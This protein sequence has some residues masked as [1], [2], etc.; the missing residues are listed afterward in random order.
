M[1]SLTQIV[2]GASVGEAVCGKKAGNKAL[3]WGAI[4]GTIPD[5][6]V[7]AS[8]FLDLV[9]ELYYHRS[10][11]HS[12]LFA[13]LASPIFGWMV[14][15]IDKKGEA[16]F[17]DWTW[18]FF[19]GFTTHVLLDCFTTWGTKV[20]YPFSDYAVSFHNIFVIDPLY[21]IPFLI[22][23]VV[24]MFYHRKDQR[25]SYWNYT[26]IVISSAYMLLTLINKQIV[27]SVMVENL[28]DQKKSYLR[29]STKPTPFN[30]IL[31]SGTAE[32]DSGYFIGY[33]SFFDK[34][35]KV[36]FAYFPK[37]HHLLNPYWED[38][39]LQTLLNITEGYYTVEDRGDSLLIND[40]RFGQLDGWGKGEEG[41]AFVYIVQPGKG[42]LS[43]SQVPNDTKKA[44][45]LLGDL[46]KRIG[47]EE[48]F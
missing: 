1:D 18:L 27:N 36:D 24:L 46:W 41:F 34:D 8:P 22:C 45:A 7:L 11:T 3:L 4:A 28:N 21:T 39:K 40:L 12:I 17:Y 47:G 14:K 33:Y 13:F 15:R 31:W 43:F 29:Y 5:L 10:I 30:A 23:T 48:N 20:F 9:G 26:G 6:D 32:T 42:S 16:S 44:R 19:L 25:R 38:K 2:L 37:N 35:K